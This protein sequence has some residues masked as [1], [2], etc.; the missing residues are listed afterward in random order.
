[1]RPKSEWMPDRSTLPRSVPQFR[2][3]MGQRCGLVMEGKP[4]LWAGSFTPPLIENQVSRSLLPPKLS[5][6][7]LQIITK[8]FS[9]NKLMC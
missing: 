1:M 7:S 5:I 9:E 2:V 8:L 3:A 4:S 6:S